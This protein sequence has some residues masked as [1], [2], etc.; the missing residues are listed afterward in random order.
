MKTF[1][2]DL[3]EYN[4]YMNNELIRA[5]VQNRNT[6]SEKSLKWMNH[7]LNAHELYNCRI[8]PAGYQPPGTWDMRSL[9]ELA[10]I[11]EN[12]FQ[13]SLGIVRLYDFDTVILY[14]TLKGMAMENTVGDILFHIVNH[15]TY[16]R[17]QIAADFR[18]TG[19][20]PL[21]SDFVIY[22]RK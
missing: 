22:R 12:N 16:H 6:V 9:E 13:V 21:V 14:T 1:F 11:N 3:F 17:G 10:T 5:M 19:L 7:I 18:N 4:R 15:S 8:E 2:N 20:E